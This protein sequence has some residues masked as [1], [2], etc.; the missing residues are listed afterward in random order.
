MSLLKGK[1]SLQNARFLSHFYDKVTDYDWCA[2]E[3]LSDIMNIRESSYV[4]KFSDSGTFSTSE[5]T[6]VMMCVATNR[7]NY[8]KFLLF[9]YFVFIFCICVQFT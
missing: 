3:L 5:L 2:A 8:F 9:F 1:S 4:L 7:S 6:C